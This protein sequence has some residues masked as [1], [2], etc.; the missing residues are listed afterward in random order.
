MFSPVN[1]LWLRSLSLSAARQALAVHA[2]ATPAIKLLLTLPGVD[3]AAGLALLEKHVSVCGIFG[4]HV[5]STLDRDD[6]E[7]ANSKL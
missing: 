5:Q 3:Y 6:A 4:Q 7:L 1:L 2:Q